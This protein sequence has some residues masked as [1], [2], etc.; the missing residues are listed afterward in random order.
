MLLAAMD[1]RHRE[2]AANE[3]VE[4]VPAAASDFCVPVLSADF[5]C[6]PERTGVFCS[7]ANVL[8][9]L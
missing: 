9:T 1:K 5:L 4:D 7:L 3:V 6:G 2:P 8:G